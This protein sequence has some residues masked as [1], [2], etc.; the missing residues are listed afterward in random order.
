[1]YMYTGWVARRPYCVSFVRVR[2][3]P[4]VVP[5]CFHCFFSEQTSIRS[6][7]VVALILR[8]EREFP[9]AIYYVY[10]TQDIRYV[11]ILHMRV[12][13]TSR[14]RATPFIIA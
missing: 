7:S 2:M 9:H 13:C 3:Y 1:M 5:L 6:S 12:K 8:Q 10:V 4:D 14:A 11:L